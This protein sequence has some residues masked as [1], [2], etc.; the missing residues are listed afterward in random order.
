VKLPARSSDIEAGIPEL[1]PKPNCEQRNK[2]AEEL[3]ELSIKLS[4]AASQMREF[5]N[6]DVAAF[7][8]AKAEMQRLRDDCDNLRAELYRHRAHH[9]C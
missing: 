9:G 2:L 7:E 1:Q 8:K 5:A 3:V 6:T 4:I